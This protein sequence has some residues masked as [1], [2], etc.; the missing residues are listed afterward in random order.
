MKSMNRAINN[1]IY[2]VP[3]NSRE[4]A[5]TNWHSK[6]GEII[7]LLSQGTQTT[8]IKIL[9]LSTHFLDENECANRD[10]CI[11]GVCLNNMGSFRC[12]CPQELT[13][14]ASGRYCQGLCSTFIVNITLNKI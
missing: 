8:A 14:D 12:Q 2:I 3:R 5:V 7:F 4:I 9:S 11:D 10:Q 6:H 13:L 1:C